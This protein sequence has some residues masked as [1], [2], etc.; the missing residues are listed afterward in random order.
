MPVIALT[1]E[2]GSL[3]KE[4]ANEVAQLLQLRVLKHEVEGHVAGKMNVSTS[5]IRRLREGKAGIIERFGADT[6]RIALL[7]AEEVCAQAAVGNVVLRGW[8]ATCLLRPVSHVLR[9]RITRPLAQR[10]AWLMEHLETDDAD[11]AEAEIR[12]SDEAHASRMHQ[13]FG[14]TWGDPLLYDVVINTDRVS[15]ESAAGQIAQLTTR[16][17]FAETPQS[18]DMVQRL[19]LE[20]RIRAAL[21]DREATREVKV[22]IEPQPGGQVTL[23]GI[24]LNEEER[25]LTAQVVAGVDGVTAVDNQLRLMASS[26][27]FASA[28]Y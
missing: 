4:V 21:Q 26:R 1:Q 25:G 9:V 17:E 14:V 5:L 11:F 20:W 10:V 23:R 7:T 22:T 24:V 18:A 27:R 19:A 28:K 16:P 15:V 3:A 2:M 8:G 13:Q 12:R 6:G